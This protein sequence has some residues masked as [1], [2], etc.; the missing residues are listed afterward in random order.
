MARLLLGIKVRWLS[1]FLGSPRPWRRLVL[2]L[3]CTISVSTSSRVTWLIAAFRTLIGRAVRRHGFY[4]ISTLAK[5]LMFIRKAPSA[6]CS[7]V[8]GEH[9]GSCIVPDS[10]VLFVLGDLTSLRTIWVQ[11]CLQLSEYHLSKV[12]GL[13]EP[14]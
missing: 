14:L 8:D 13:E 4:M 9:I 2:W 3:S 1:F 6:L 7:D 5:C 11:V 12:S 10:P